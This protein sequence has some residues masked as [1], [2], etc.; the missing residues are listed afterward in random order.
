MVE[1]EKERERERENIKYNSGLKNIAHDKLPL[2]RTNVNDTHASIQYEIM[3]TLHTH[4][5][6]D[7]INFQIFTKKINILILENFDMSR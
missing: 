7:K 2:L 4:I 5:L 3:I 1:R 6:H